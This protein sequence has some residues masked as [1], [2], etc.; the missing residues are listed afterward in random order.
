LL[1]R[2]P[3]CPAD[4]AARRDGAPSCATRTFLFDEPLSNLDASWRC[5]AH[6]NQGTASAAKTTTVYVTH[7]QIEAMTMADK[8]V[9]MHDGIVGNRSAR[10]LELLRQTGQSVRRRLYR[11]PA[12]ISSKAR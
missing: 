5:D 10:P 8:I 2:I 1:D 11:F 4:N 9:V 3:Q 7:D 12:M 6:R